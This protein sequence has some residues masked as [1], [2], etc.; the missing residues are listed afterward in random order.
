MAI[1]VGQFINQR[2]QPL[3]YQNPQVQSAQNASRGGVTLPQINVPQIPNGTQANTM[4]QLQ[5]ILGLIARGAGGGG[6][7][8]DMGNTLAPIAQQGASIAN[9]PAAF[10]RQFGLDGLLGG[11]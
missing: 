9:D 4:Q 3:Q 5:G 1:G 6:N 2:V 10:L 11:R 7:V 8:Q